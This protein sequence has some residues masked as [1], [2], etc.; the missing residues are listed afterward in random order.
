MRDSENAQSA[1]DRYAVFGNPIEH[2]KSPLIHT[3]FAEQ[4][5]QSLV[6]DKQQV[7]PD[8]FVQTADAFFSE[9]GKGLNITVPFK[10]C[11]FEYAD[12]LSA[13]ARL[14]GAVNTLIKHQDGGIE[15]DNTDGVGM[16]RDMT[17][18]L[19]WLIK[20]KRTLVLG[21]GGA[22]RGVLGPLLEAGPSSVT[23]ANRTVTKAETLV[24]VFSDLG[25]INSCGYEELEDLCDQHRFDVVI[26][27]TAASLAGDL[28]P[29]PD[30]LLS[31]QASCYDMMYSKEPTVF[32]QW[33]EQHG[34]S[35]AVDGLGMLVE[36][37]AESFFLWRGV[38]PQTQPVVSELRAV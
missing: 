16:L 2:S 11:A 13:R 4:T 9:G 7:E 38:R 30:N 24:N 15:G 29:L 12:T 20:S 26:N 23:V 35:Q 32:M 5:Q 36:Q 18:N 10:Q 3:R 22:V 27:G 21:A 28:P 19:G 33:A 8:A 25:N 17:E 1:H 6:Y 34:A 37:A 31:D 14:A